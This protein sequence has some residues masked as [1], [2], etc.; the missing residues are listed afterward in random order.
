[1]PPYD[2]AIVVKE[3]S[4][5]SPMTALVRIPLPADRHPALVYL[6]QLS[7]G[8]RRSMRTAL[9]TIAE[10]LGVAPV[11]QETS[12][13]R[14]RREVETLLYCDWTSLRYQHTL[15]LRTLLA[16]RYKPATANKMLAALRRV[17]LE[18][19]RLGLMTPDDYAQ[20]ADIGSIKGSS[21]PP[22]RALSMGE[23]TAL[24]AACSADPTPAGPRDAALIAL[25]SRG[26][27]RRSEAV[28]LDLADYLPDSGAVT[29]RS[30]KG[31]KDRTTY[32]DGGAAAAL[33]DWLVVRG[34]TAGPLLCPVN[35][36]RRITIRRLSDQAVL[37]ALQKRAKQA[38]VK[39]FSP[40]D[41]RRT[42]I[43]D[44]LDAGADIAT[45]QR[46]AGHA[47]PETTSRYDRRGEA[48]KR[49]A[50]SLLHLAYDAR[51]GGTE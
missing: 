34:A 48:T 20:A 18:A 10:L 42:F 37:G 23:L 12:S 51:T 38:T 50:A 7:P 35:K 22:G 40:H 17:L 25:L 44:L 47:S 26:G 3:S 21:L 4:S 24:M 11:V 39:G 15:A 14:R 36:G 6:A 28:A 45:V 19:R 13:P 33:A 46:M 30:G 43:S 16:E 31:R 9:N 27:L 2:A 5:D 49:R 29:V 1:M 8:S 41:L 32:L